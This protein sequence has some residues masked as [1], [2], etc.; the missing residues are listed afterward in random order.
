MDGVEGVVC[1]V[2]WETSGRAGSDGKILEVVPY[3]DHPRLPWLSPPQG[4]GASQC[5]AWPSHPQPASHGVA[6]VLF[7]SVLPTSQRNRRR[8]RGKG[9]H[10]P[11]MAQAGA[12]AP[13]A[14]H[15]LGWEAQTGC[16]H[17]PD[18][19]GTALLGLAGVAGQGSNGQRVARHLP[20]A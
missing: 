14:M 9:E 8:P 12:G 16:V 18:W 17:G 3:R 1:S 5:W 15:G 7:F 2:V 4:A 6:M 19:L 20:L 13:T 10:S 11:S